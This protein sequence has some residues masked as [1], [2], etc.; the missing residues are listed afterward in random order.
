MRIFFAPANLSGCE[1]VTRKSSMT[2]CLFSASW[3]AAIVASTCVVQADVFGLQD[4]SQWA[5]QVEDMVLQP[6]MSPPVTHRMELGW[7]APNL[8][9]RSPKQ[10]WP[11]DGADVLPWWRLTPGG[12]QAGLV[13]EF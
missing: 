4:T 5:E 7:D 6:D 2:R 10:Q 9:E 13:L 11:A 8:N 12:G 3:I 1:T